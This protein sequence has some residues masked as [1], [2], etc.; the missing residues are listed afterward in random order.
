M[1]CAGKIDDNSLVQE[2]CIIGWNVARPLLQNHLRSNVH[3]FFQLATAALDTLSS[4][5]TQLRMLLHFELSKCEEQ[6]DFIVKAR[7]ECHKALCKDYGELGESKSTNGEELNRNRNL[8]HIMKPFYE[9]LQLRG[10]VYDT[11]T[12]VESNVVLMLQQIKESTSISFQRDM[13]GKAVYC[14]LEVCRNPEFEYN[15]DKKLEVSI[16]SVSL[17]TISNVLEV[18]RGNP[19]TAYSVFT[20]LAYQRLLIWN[21]ISKIAHAQRNVLFMQH[22]AVMLL[23]D[24]WSNDDQFVKPIVDMQIEAHFI[25]IESFVEQ[26]AK[27]TISA[28]K[29]EVM[30]KDQMEL[31]EANRERKQKTK[32]TSPFALGL[33]SKYSTEE[34]EAIKIITI[35]TLKRALQ[36]ATLAKTEAGNAPRNIS[37]THTLTYSLT[38]A[39]K[40]S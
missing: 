20:E 16:A 38:Q 28:D 39:F 11:P 22:S 5:L 2:I 25:L 36:L 30:E 33:T 14:M 3:R 6:A 13:L 31:D 9:T 18:D 24:K 15:S 32:L 35:S 21:D 27:L 26:L 10:N 19:S 37:H 8:D 29:E 1:M 23:Q 17:E 40:T 7:D 12:D 34:M 4:T